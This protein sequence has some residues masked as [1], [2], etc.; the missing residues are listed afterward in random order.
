MVSTTAIEYLHSEELRKRDVAANEEDMVE[1][2]TEEDRELDNELL[3]NNEAP[4][5]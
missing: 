4:Q 2:I 5:I 1:M 3:R